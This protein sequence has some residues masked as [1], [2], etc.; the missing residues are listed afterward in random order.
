MDKEIKE[1]KV[2]PF[3]FKLPKCC[4]ENHEDCPHRIDNRV[5]AKTP[6][7]KRNIGL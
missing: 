1:E 7:I 2:E 4:E 6:R 5:K 3:T